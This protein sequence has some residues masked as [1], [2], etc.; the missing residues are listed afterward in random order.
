MSVLAEHRKQRSFYFLYGKDHLEWSIIQ[1]HFTGVCEEAEEKYGTLIKNGFTQRRFLAPCKSVPTST[2]RGH[3]FGSGSLVLFFS[4]CFPSPLQFPHW[5][6]FHFL[7]GS[8][9]LHT[10]LQ[11]GSSLFWETSCCNYLSPLSLS[12]FQEN[13][14]AVECVFFSA[15]QLQS[16]VEDAFFIKY[17]FFLCLLS[18]SM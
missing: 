14:A 6:D 2:S 5:L 7:Q 18:F 4:S 15:H 10:C 17:P 16:R 12:V 13:F 11:R 8:W 9:Y 1:G 3:Q